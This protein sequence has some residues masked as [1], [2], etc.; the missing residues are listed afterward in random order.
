MVERLLPLVGTEIEYGITDF[1]PQKRERHTQSI[2]LELKV[3]NQQKQFLGNGARFYRDIGAHPEYCTPECLTARDIVAW[4]KAGDEIALEVVGRRARE[5]GLKDGSIVLIRSNCDYT[6]ARNSFGYHENYL[7]PRGVDFDKLAKILLTHLPTREIYT[8]SGWWNLREGIFELSPRAG[9]ITQDKTSGHTAKGIINTR[10]EPLA[11]FTDWRRIHIVGGSPN[12]SEYPTYLK[13]G[14]TQL[15]INMAIAGALDYP[16]CL[17]LKPF[18]AIKQVSRDTS[19]KKTLD[20]E[21][22]GARRSPLYI[23]QLL[24]WQAYRFFQRERS[25]ENSQEIL[26]AWGF[27]LDRLA[28]DPRSLDHHLDWVIERGVLETYA[29]EHERRKG[30]AITSHDLASFDMMYH[31]IGPRSVFSSIQRRTRIAR[32]V[33]DEE[34]KYAIENPPRGT[35]AWVRGSLIREAGSLGLELDHADWTGLKF[36]Q[37]E[38]GKFYMISLEDPFCSGM[39]VLSASEIFEGIK[40]GK[41]PTE[42]KHKPNTDASL[43]HIPFIS[44]RAAY[45]NPPSGSP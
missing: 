1:P 14:I 10:D 7:V 8:G 27:V 16:P 11:C 26:K 19:C 35:R 17:L 28:E 43:G 45:Y 34:I 39:Q 29:Q 42:A 36:K 25:D 30:R 9:S 4:E 23:Q 24:C 2:D 44:P 40:E 12:M 41:Y 15:V 20:T 38:E 21:D 3:G 18:T 33:T 6:Q 32:V 22:N 37:A 5:E 31:A 13:I